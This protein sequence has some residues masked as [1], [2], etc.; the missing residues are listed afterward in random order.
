MIALESLDLFDGV[1]AHLPG[2]AP[3]GSLGSSQTP[4]ATQTGWLA[5]QT[6]PQNDNAVIVA[7][8]DHA[9]PFA[10][11]LLT[12]HGHSRVA[13]IWLMDA[14]MRDRRPDIP[15]GQEFRGPDID[16]LIRDAGDEVA[17]CRAAGLPALRRAASHGAAV[18]ALA[19]G[20]DPDDPRG[21]GHPV[22]AVSLPDFAVA[23]TS[24]SYSALFIQAAVIFVIARARGLARAMSQA[25]GRRLRPAVV[26]NLSLGVSAGGLDGSSIIAR[27]Q[28]AIAQEAARDLGP[29]HF[30]LPTGNSR[31][32]QLHATLRAG[33]EIGWFLPPD[34]ATPSAV[35]FWGAPGPA[36]I[37]LR[38]TLPDGQS[39]TTSF[40]ANTRAARLCDAQG[41]E[42]ARAILQMRKVDMTR[43]PCL[44]LIAAPT[45]AQQ[46]AA[47]PPG[48]WRLH[49]TAGSA[50]PCK[51]FVQRDDSLSGLSGGGRQSRLEVPG[52]QARDDSGR[53]RGADPAPLP[54]PPPLI[55]RDDTASSYTGGRFQFRVGATLARPQGA[56]AAYSGLLADGQ[57]GDVSAPSDASNSRRGM[58]TPGVA[59]AA[60]QR[61]SGTSLSA[62]QLTRWLAGRLA[63]G[64]SL[65]DRAALRA[66][67]GGGDD[68]PDLGPPDLPW[69]CGFG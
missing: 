45:L 65:A 62:P 22:V 15:F 10:H 47:A 48:H 36:R 9:I 19:A 57:N 54:H 28:D 18:T 44:T 39:A 13:A 21:R 41:R 56:L 6:M 46:G 25:A 17:A 24:G 29:V 31:Q 16:A 49:L 3:A 52:W 7:V 58:V 14:P 37:N 38:V 64:E 5:A 32:A 53:W 68:T 43:R 35:E 67:L 23:D 27:F 40:A 11:R 20:Y 8:I 51:V 55:R 66:A 1:L 34:D 33:D 63:A 60:R 69:R 12:H 2:L 61:L 26:V 4:A 50:T 42:F 59:G 30:V